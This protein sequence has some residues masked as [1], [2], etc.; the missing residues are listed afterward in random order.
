MI[1]RIVE[2]LVEARQP[3]MSRLKRPMKIKFARQTGR[4]PMK[5]T[6]NVGGASDIPESYTRYLRR[7]LASA[8]HWEHLPIVI[9]YQK[10]ENPFDD[11]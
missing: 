2:K 9:E 3:P 10:D 1:N 8:L 6:I 7:G 4:H 11:K 5:I